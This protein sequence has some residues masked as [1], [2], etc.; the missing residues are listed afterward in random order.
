MR[1]AAVSTF[2]MSDMNRLLMGIMPKGFQR[3]SWADP[4]QKL[5]SASARGRTPLF[6]RKEKAF[7]MA[8][9]N[10]EKRFEF[11]RESRSFRTLRL[12]WCG[13]VSIAFA[14]AQAPA[15]PRRRR[16]ISGLGP[17][18]GLSNG[19]SRRALLARSAIGPS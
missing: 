19:S 12:I 10:S 14:F 17:R 9:V 3:R 8:D 18:Q 15:P 16:S 1:T 2:P 6:C 4:L 5:R 11:F 13:I 7:E